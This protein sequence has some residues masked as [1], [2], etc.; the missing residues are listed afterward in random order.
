MKDDVRAHLHDVIQAA[1]AVEQF[2]AGRSFDDYAS[3][4]LLRSAVER[5]FEIMGEALSRIRRDE[6]DVLRHIRDHRDVISFRNILAHGYDTIDDRIVW[7]VIEKDI[8]N[9]I[10]D[11]SKLLE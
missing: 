6:P 7:D 4:E 2:V 1:R 3:D 5:K 10:T 8:A 11:A 9:L